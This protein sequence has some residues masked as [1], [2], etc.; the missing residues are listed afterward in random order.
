LSVVSEVFQRM[1]VTSRECSLIHVGYE[2][3]TIINLR[4]TDCHLSAPPH[5]ARTK[6]RNETKTKFVIVG[7]VSKRQNHVSNDL[8]LLS[9]RCRLRDSF[10]VQR[11]RMTKSTSH[12]MNSLTLFCSLI[13]FASSFVV[14]YVPFVGSRC[15]SNEGFC[16]QSAA[17]R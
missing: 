1:L 16:S 12:V 7:C 10:V 14:P 6:E 3:R 4:V 8:C 2:V 17:W 5:H 9:V 11:E 15:F 13:S